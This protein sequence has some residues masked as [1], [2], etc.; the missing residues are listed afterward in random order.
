MEACLSQ[1]LGVE[2]WKHNFYGRIIWS[3][4]FRKL[5]ITISLKTVKSFVE[6]VNNACNISQSQLPI[7][8]VKGV[9]LAIWILD[10]EYR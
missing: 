8:Y 2:P 6:A 5:K 3:K 4:G 7:P 9:R 1:R 10:E